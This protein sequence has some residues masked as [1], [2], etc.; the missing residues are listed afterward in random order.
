[1][2]NLKDKPTTL[3]VAGPILSIGILMGIGYV[4]YTLIGSIFAFKGLGLELI[5]L[6]PA[7]LFYVVQIIFYLALGYF[8]LR[9]IY[10]WSN[11]AIVLGVIVGPLVLVIVVSFIAG[12]FEQSLDASTPIGIGLLIFFLLTPLVMATVAYNDIRYR[13]PSLN[14]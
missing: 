5:V 2:I 3:F 12:K 4:I 6:V 9:G 8:L 7:M 14:R 10:R 11:V 1:M 13:K